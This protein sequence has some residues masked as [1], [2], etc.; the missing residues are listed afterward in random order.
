MSSIDALF[1]LKLNAIG[2]LVRLFFEDRKKKFLTEVTLLFPSQENQKTFDPRSSTQFRI[3]IHYRFFSYIGIC[4]GPQ[5]IKIG[6]IFFFS[7][8]L[9]LWYHPPLLISG[10]LIATSYRQ[11]WTC[12]HLPQPPHV[13]WLRLIVIEALLLL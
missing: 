1:T 13:T 9:T 5:N 12:F 8:K 11:I 4:S 10:V 3:Q 7:Q 2:F 6:I